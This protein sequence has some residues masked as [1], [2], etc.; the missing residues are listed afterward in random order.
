MATGEER[1]LISPCGLH[2]GHCPLYQ[3]RADEVLRK[4]IAER[5]GIPIEKVLVCNGCRPSQGK[6]PS[7]GGNSACDTFVCAVNERGIEFCYECDDFPC[8]KLAPCADRAQEI[9][10]NTKVYHLVL[11]QKLGIDAWLDRYESLSK[12]YRRGKKPQAGGDIQL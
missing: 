6:V 10:H 4:K 2:C 9:P 12:Q 1:A 7:L 11:L 3:A 5:Q 8:L